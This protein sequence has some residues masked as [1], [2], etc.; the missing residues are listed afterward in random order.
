M[1][2][3]DVQQ[4]YLLLADI[5]GYTAFLTGT[6]LDH[7]TGVID[8]LTSCVVEHLPPPLRLVKLEGD[9]VFTYA[10]HDVFSNGERALE[11]IEQCYIA[12]CDRIAD[13]IRQTTCTCAAC[14]NVGTLDLKF[15]AHFGEF[16]VQH[17][18]RGDDLAG[19]DVIVVHRLLPQPA[20]LASNSHSAGTRGSGW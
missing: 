8:D 9:A 7:A 12:F 19:G 6:E 4:G 13:V 11:L 2:N 18:P 17:G 10:P 20:G 1:P 3:P 16:V 14:A 15:V 5:S